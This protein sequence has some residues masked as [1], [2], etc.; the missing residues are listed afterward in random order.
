M[1]EEKEVL[2]ALFTRTTALCCFVRLQ[3]DDYGF[4]PRP[5][6]WLPSRWSGCGMVQHPRRGWT[7]GQAAL[8]TVCCRMPVYRA[9][10]RTASGTTAG[11]H[12]SADAD[13]RASSAALRARASVSPSSRWMGGRDHRIVLKSTK[14]EMSNIAR[15][16][17]CAGYHFYTRRSVPNFSTITPSSSSFESSIFAVV[18]EYDSFAISSSRGHGCARAS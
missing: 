2:Y 1:R 18:T 13:V 14:T 6:P 11:H 16:C 8:G 5:Q 9:A 4:G 7:C 15:A 17:K 12:R 3:H 10:A